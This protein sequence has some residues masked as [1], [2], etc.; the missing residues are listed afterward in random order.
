MQNVYFFTE[1]SSLTSSQC[2]CLFIMPC[3]I[4]YSLKQVSSFLLLKFQ[5]LKNALLYEQDIPK[6]VRYP[7]AGNIFIY[8]YLNNT[9]QIWVLKTGY[10]DCLIADISQYI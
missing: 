6:Y 3:N 5:N 8:F 10:M 4:C 7:T 9:Y 1:M 2:R